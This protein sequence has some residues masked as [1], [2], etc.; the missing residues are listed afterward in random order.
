MEVVEEPIITGIIE[1]IRKVKGHEIVVMDLQKIEQSVGNFFVLCT[2][3]SSVQVEAIYEA[4]REEVEKTTEELPHSVEG[5]QNKQWI[6]VDYAD[7]VVHIFLKPFRSHYRLEEL[8]G[9]ASMKHF[10]D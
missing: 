8:W 5:R 9:D 7:V 1:G 6:I 4:I 2:G 3:D 10:S